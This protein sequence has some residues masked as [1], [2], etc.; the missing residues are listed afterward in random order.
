MQQAPARGW[1]ERRQWC[2]RV[3][4]G[5]N[6]VFGTPKQCNNALRGGNGSRK[7]ATEGRGGIAAAE[8]VAPDWLLVPRASGSRVGMGTEIREFPAGMCVWRR[9]GVR[10]ALTGRDRNR[11]FH[12]GVS[13]SLSIINIPLNVFLDCFFLISVH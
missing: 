9:V 7:G 2:V 12:V 3:I 5:E 8:R 1:D 6:C 11:E 13:P 4:A 10:G